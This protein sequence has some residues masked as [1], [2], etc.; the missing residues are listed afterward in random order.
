VRAVPNTKCVGVAAVVLAGA[1]AAS[2]FLL[3]RG[4]GD[5]GRAHGTTSTTRVPPTWTTY[6]NDARGLT[7]SHP[8]D[9]FVAPQNL[10]PHLGDANRPWEIVSLG[11]SPRLDPADHNCAHVPVNALEN[12]GPTDA[13]ISVQ[14]RRPPAN[15]MTGHRPRRFGP[16]SG[17]DGSQTEVVEC[18]STPPAATFRW[19]P[20]AAAG[21]EFYVI[22]AIGA[23]ATEQE[24]DD[25]YRVLDTMI[26]RAVQ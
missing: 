22:V 20:F 2:A 13:F 14:E 21:R 4:D 25:A 6:R 3:V 15:E 10:T 9:W 8:H 7:L 17:I 12:L 19:I 11:T 18:L 5:A 16:E 24:R 26:I 23:D 1:A